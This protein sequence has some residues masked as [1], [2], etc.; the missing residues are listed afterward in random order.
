MPRPERKELT[1]D[2]SEVMEEVES[3]ASE[4]WVDSGPLAEL[5]IQWI[6]SLSD[7]M[8]LSRPDGYMQWTF[9][10]A[11]EWINIFICTHKNDMCGKCGASIQD[12]HT[13]KETTT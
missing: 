7:G 13:H 6:E 8:G 9:K 3:I 5:H 12:G 4:A 10:Q 2:I 1:L 11:D